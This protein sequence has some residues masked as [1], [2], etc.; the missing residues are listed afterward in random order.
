MSVIVQ[1]EF[2]VGSDTAI[3][4]HTPTTT[5]TGYTV[6]AGGMTVIAATDV[7]A[8][9]DANGGHRAGAD[10]S[11]GSPDMIVEGDFA[12]AGSGSL[13]GHGV[14]GRKGTPGG[15]AGVEFVYD[16]STGEWVLG[17]DT[18]SES[19]PGGT[20]NMRLE[21][22]GGTCY[23]YVNDVL[24]V[25][26]TIAESGNYAGFV[27]FDFD[28]DGGGNAATMTNFLVQSIAE[29]DSISEGADLDATFDALLSK[30]GALSEGASLDATFDAIAAKLESFTAGVTMGMSLGTAH[31]TFF[32]DF[33]VAVA[34]SFDALAALLASLE[35]GVDLDASFVGVAGSAALGA[36]SEAA[37]VGA[38]F[39][40]LAARLEGLSEDVVMGTS[41]AGLAELLAQ[42]SHGVSMGATFSPAYGLIPCSA[43]TG[44]LLDEFVQTDDGSVVN[45][46]A[47]FDQ[48]A[49]SWQSGADPTALTGVC[50]RLRRV[51]TPTGTMRVNV[52]AHS[53]TYGS[54]G[55]PTGAALVSSELYNISALTTSAAGYFFA[56][57]GWTPDP[58]TSYFVALSDVDVVGDGSN[59]VRMTMESGVEA[60]HEGN[61]AVDGGG[62][63]GT[64][65]GGADDLAFKLYAES[66][67]IVLYPLASRSAPAIHDPVFSPA[68]ME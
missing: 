46:V 34:A 21:C 31:T 38:A 17:T 43:A 6:Q 33:D 37:S 42:S 20:V 13:K 67:G 48:A 55:I 30:L 8:G 68:F 59:F 24:K 60:T 50:F 18:L 49:Q 11:V 16:N 40:A 14:A 41:F 2:T 7:V 64:L 63:W 58:S 27:L 65:G 12:W 28:D 61:A 35:E 36:L 39:A 52:Y 5:G 23:G 1:D 25:Q 19:W 15:A 3:G 47:T 26:D 53:G 45:L 66:G 51:G 29:S 4:S 10:D 44:V 56:L 9:D 62:S 22:R 32:D 54:T 57:S